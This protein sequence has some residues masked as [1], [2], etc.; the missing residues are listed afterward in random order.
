MKKR[1]S[2]IRLVPGEIGFM[3]AGE[4]MPRGHSEITAGAAVGGG[5][6]YPNEGWLV[7]GLWSARPRN[8]SPVGT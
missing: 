2:E 4:I 6:A 8:L 7:G 5:Y 1:K 3:R